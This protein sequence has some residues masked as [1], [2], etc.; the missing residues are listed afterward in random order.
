[1]L[2]LIKNFW[3]KL[4]TILDML[5]NFLSILL[6]FDFLSLL[7]PW[8]EFSLIPIIQSIKDLS[9]VIL[10]LMIF[11]HLFFTG[12]CLCIGVPSGPLCVS[13]IPYVCVEQ[14]DQSIVYSNVTEFTS[15]LAIIRLT[16]RTR[17][18]VCMYSNAVRLR[19]R[20]YSTFT[21]Y[22]TV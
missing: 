20:T 13:K 2:E 5:Q 1:M 11:H 16:V 10:L 22:S 7:Y 3:N 4:F 6:C 17:L 15:T 12:S 19:G 21:H 8:N 18:Y 14:Y 9:K